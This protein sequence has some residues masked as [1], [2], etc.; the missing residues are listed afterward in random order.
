MTATV[1]T[2]ATETMIAKTMIAATTEDIVPGH[3]LAENLMTVDIGLPGEM[4]MRGGLPQGTMIII[5]A[6]IM[7]TV[8]VLILTLTVVGTNT[9][10][11]VTTED[12]MKEIMTTGLQGQRSLRRQLPTVMRDGVKK[13]SRLDTGLWRTKDPHT[14]HR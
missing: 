13:E 5:D 4:I 11:A 8:E 3:H 9:T 7:T 2:I 12:A 10:A 1:V 6:L 14:T